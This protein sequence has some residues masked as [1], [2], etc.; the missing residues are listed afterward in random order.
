MVSI[1]LVVF[2][3][4]VLSSPAILSFTFFSDVA[5]DD[6]AFS[7]ALLYPATTS[8]AFSASLA[9]A[10]AAPAEFEAACAL[11]S[12]AFAL[13]SASDAFSFAVLAASLASVTKFLKSG[14]ASPGTE[15]QNHLSVLSP[16]DGRT[17][18]VSFSKHM[19]EPP[20]YETI[21]KKLYV[22]ESE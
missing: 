6:A 18:I 10:A 16:G 19:Y 2:S 13:V 11:I 3:E 4:N 1:A 7:A 9:E 17:P 21:S 22:L 8:F 12:E 15:E 20:S 14:V 5:A